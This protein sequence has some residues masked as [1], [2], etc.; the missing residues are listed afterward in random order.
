ML[1]KILVAIDNSTLGEH[2][3]GKALTLAQ[4]TGACLMLLHV[5]SDE[6]IGYPNVHELADHL[7]RWEA[8]KQRGLALLQSRQ[9][10]AFKAGIYTE[11][12]QTPGTSE[13]TICNMARDW[14]ADVIV[15]GHRGLSGL[16]ELVHSSVSN[17]LVHHA[18]CSVLTVVRQA[19]STCQSLLVAIDGSDVS[20]HAFDEALALAKATGAALHLVN[21]ISVEDKGS[22][23]ILSL[24]DPDFERQW[25]AFA[26]PR[27]DVLRSH[28]EIATKAGVTAEIH[29]KLGSS[30]GRGICELAHSLKT[31]L[32]VV[33]RRGLSGLSELLMGSVSNYIV[34]YAPCAV[35]TVQGPI[36][37]SPAA[38]AHQMAGM[39]SA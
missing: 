19:K 11:F 34:H 26:Q 9:A 35:L 29:Q 15:V 2:V 39:A 37:A 30:P 1:E 12:S 23:S 21:V 8:P 6:E 14:K 27:L 4:A 36:N 3:F 13:R 25:Q 20:R 5:L 10:I 18:P 17:Y 7:D 32:I 16:Q 28:Q 24:K 31:D 22:P 38:P 33:G